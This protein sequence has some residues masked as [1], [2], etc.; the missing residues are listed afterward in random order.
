M[1]TEPVFL[2]VED[3]EFSRTV[4]ELLLTRALG[5]T[6]LTMFEDSSNFLKKMEA[7]SLKPDLIF[8]DIHMKPD[9]G[10]A[11]LTLLRSHE[12]YC[13]AKVVAVTASVMNEEV[14]LLKEAGFD[15]ALAKPLDIGFCSEFIKRTINGE[16]VWHIG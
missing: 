14:E 10:F 8:L 7:L 13:K 3:D 15:G 6:Q 1:N 9:D 12:S 16:R 5:F 4:M 2:Y 11:L